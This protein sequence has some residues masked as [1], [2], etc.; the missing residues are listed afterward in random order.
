MW[1]QFDKIGKSSRAGNT[2]GTYSNALLVFNH[3][4]VF[5]ILAFPSVSGLQSGAVGQTRAHKFVS[6]SIAVKGGYL[7]YRVRRTCTRTGPNPPP[8]PPPPTLTADPRLLFQARPLQRGIQL[9]NIVEGR[10]VRLSAGLM[11][12]P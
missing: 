7:L 9:G 12:T 10:G 11:K 3:Y 8:P 4:T 5:V 1:L 2:S 6:S